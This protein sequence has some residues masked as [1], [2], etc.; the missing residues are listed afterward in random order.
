MIR[1]VPRLDGGRARNKFGAL[2]EQMYCAEES[3][4]NIVGTFRR[5]GHSAFP[6][7]SVRPWLWLP[8]WWSSFTQCCPAN[9]VLIWVSLHWQKQ[10]YITY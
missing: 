4:R 9:H 5:Q 8:A 2:W 6:R 3:T 10:L 7:P 1:G